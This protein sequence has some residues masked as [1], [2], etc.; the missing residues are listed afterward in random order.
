MKVGTAFYGDIFFL[1]IIVVVVPFEV[2]SYWVAESRISLSPA[3][4]FCISATIY[5]RSKSGSLF[6]CF[7]GELY[8]TSADPCG[9]LLWF[10][11]SDM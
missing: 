2:F 5:M 9:S 4:F 6:N 10:A 11:G 1:A 8:G 3:V 7:F